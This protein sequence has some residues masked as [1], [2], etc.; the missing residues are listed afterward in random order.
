MPKDKKIINTKEIDKETSKNKSNEKTKE[1]SKEV[2]Q[3]L[4]SNESKKIMSKK[5]TELPVADIKINNKTVLKDK[6]NNKMDNKEV[7]EKKIVSKKKVKTSR[8]QTAY[9][10]FMKIKMTE[11]EA[12]NQTEKL[13][14]IAKSWKELADK[15]KNKYRQEAD[16]KKKEFFEQKEQIQNESGKKK[17]LPNAYNIFLKERMQLIVGDNQKDKLIKIASEWKNLDSKNKTVFME[18]ASKLREEQVTLG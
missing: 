13:K 9:N 11:I 15:D 17:R 2:S 4:M 8:P 3:K 14:I 1:K 10:I 16:I 18:K 5:T 7:V 12:P 6:N